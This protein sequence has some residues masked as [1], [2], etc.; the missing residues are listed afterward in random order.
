MTREEAL[1]KVEAEM[2]GRLTESFNL[3]RRQ[4]AFPTNDELAHEWTQLKRMLSDNADAIRRLI[5]I[6][7]GKTIDAPA[8]PANGKPA[9]QT[10]VRK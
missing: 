7:S 2:Q 10:Q 4:K 3:S 1:A 5:A 6:A 8:P 9:A